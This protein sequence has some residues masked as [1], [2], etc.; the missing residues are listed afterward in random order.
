MKEYIERDTLITTFNNT[1]WYSI[2]KKGK[3]ILGASDED[4]ALFKASDVFRTL[5]EVPT[6]PVVHGAWSLESDEEMPDFMF[7]LVICSA[8]GEKANHTYNY[9]PNCGAKMDGGRN[10]E[11]S[12][13]C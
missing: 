5:R 7:K 2:N 13:K 9:C 10:N 11:R 1:D 12:K 3:L 4:T 6:A 8:C